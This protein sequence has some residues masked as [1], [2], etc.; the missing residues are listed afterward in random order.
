MSQLTEVPA[1]RGLLTDT[2]T[3]Q[4]VQTVLRLGY[5]LHPAVATPRRDLAEV[6]LDG[7]P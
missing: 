4:V 1:L 3:A 7:G 6:L 5:A 2:A